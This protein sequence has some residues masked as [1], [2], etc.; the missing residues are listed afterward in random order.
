M[1]IRRDVTGGFVIDDDGSEETGSVFTAAERQAMLD[2]IEARWTEQV[3]T[4]TGTQHNLSITASSLEADV[5]LCN[6]AS[7]LTITGIAAPASPSRPGKPLAIFSAGA[8]NVYL[9]HQH[10]SSSAANR[11]VNHVT[12]GLTPLAAGAGVAILR[13]DA[14]ASRWRLVSHEQGAWITPTFAAGDFTA[15][16]SMTW[17]VASGDRVA[18]RYYLKGRQLTVT[19]YLQTTTV[20]GTP[21]TALFIGNGQFGALTL[22]PNTYWPLALVSDNGTLRNAIMSPNGTQIAISRQD[23][24]N[25]T[26]A[27]DTTTVLGTGLFEAT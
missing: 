24:G 13:Y 2:L 12:S 21:N 16:G 18:L 11:L 7:D 19:F 20:G 23:G 5:L 10:A 9:S 22:Q 4:A 17:T 1:S 14:T 6:N 15:N 27:T 3:V 25:W 26:A 8:G